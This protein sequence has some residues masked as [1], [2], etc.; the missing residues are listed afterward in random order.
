MRDVAVIGGGMTLFRRK[1]NET[2]KEL[3]YLA[4]KMAMEEAGITRKEA[5]G[6]LPQ[7]LAY[8]RRQEVPTKAPRFE[9]CYDRG[10]VQPKKEWTD[11]YYRTKKD[12]QAIG[13]RFT[14]ARD[15]Q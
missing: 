12:L 2:G 8:S 3:S 15:F 13:V 5:N 7:I 4:A 9:D 14:D 11:L 10:T 1:L 6:L